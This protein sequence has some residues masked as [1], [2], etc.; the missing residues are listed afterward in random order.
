[1]SPY[2]EC[3]TYISQGRF[4]LPYAACPTWDFH[5]NRALGLQVYLFG[6]KSMN[7]VFA[8][9]FS[10]S[11]V[12]QILRAGTPKRYASGSTRRCS[13]LSMKVAQKS[14]TKV[15]IWL[16]ISSNNRAYILHHAETPGFPIFGSCKPY[17]STSRFGR[18][19]FRAYKPS[20][21]LSLFHHHFI[22]E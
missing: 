18:L 10:I 13:Q 8:P 20:V 1:M 12:R 15:P 6:M 21:C 4:Q 22:T 3:R 17:G 16:E 5:C 11:S 2:L 9:G 14:I 7:F 19:Y